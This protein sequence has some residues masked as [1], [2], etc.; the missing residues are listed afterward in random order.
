MNKIKEIIKEWWKTA[1]F[2]AI[3]GAACFIA[4][5]CG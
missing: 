1:L 2:T 4:G 3:L 5:M